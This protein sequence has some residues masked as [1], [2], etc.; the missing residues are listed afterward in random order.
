MSSLSVALTTLC[1]R[2]DEIGP[3]YHLC[4]Y[5]PSLMITICALYVAHC[6]VHGFVGPDAPAVF[7]CVSTL[8][9]ANSIW[10]FNKDI[11]D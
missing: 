8:L 1:F 3:L 10:I 11:L 5:L 6:F 7:N 9:T 2:V 4:T